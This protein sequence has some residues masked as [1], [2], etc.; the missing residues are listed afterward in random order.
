[1]IASLR[2][3]LILSE[4][5][6]IVVECSGV[7]FRCQASDNTIR[8]LGSNGSEVFVYTYMTVREDAIELCAFADADELQMFKVLV[9]VNG[10]SARLAVSLLSEYDPDRLALFIASGDSKA[11]TK[12]AGIGA[13]LAQRIVLE[14]KDKLG[15][16]DINISADAT[17]ASAA[18]SNSATAEAVSALVSLG[19]S[20]TDASVA[21]G[22]LDK[23]LPVETL[24]KEALKQLSRQV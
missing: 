24:I 23:S 14:T 19:F 17:F 10:V 20:Q 5:R 21:V 13:K 18:A 11:L 7:G 15:A 22:K 12:A 9:N 4:S 3:T 16:A 8:S 6:S 1:M 2:G